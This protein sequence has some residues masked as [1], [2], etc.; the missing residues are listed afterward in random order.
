MS[1]NGQQ[2]EMQFSTDGGATFLTAANYAFSGVI[3]DETG[4]V[5]GSGSAILTALPVTTGIASA[6]VGDCVFEIYPGSTSVNPRMLGRSFAPNAAGH[7][8]TFNYGGGWTGTLSFINFLQLFPGAGN[9]SGT[10]IVE[11]LP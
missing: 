7:Y 1:S 8:Q 6:G 10:I 4:T 2:I 5:S 9:F 3:V 11:G